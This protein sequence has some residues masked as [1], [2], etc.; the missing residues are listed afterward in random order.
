ML[1]AEYKYD[2]YE[3][4]DI[5]KMGIRT[6]YKKDYMPHEKKA[7]IQVSIAADGA[8]SIYR[9]YIVVDEIEDKEEDRQMLLK[10][11]KKI[12]KD[13]GLGDTLVLDI[14]PDPLEF[15]RI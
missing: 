10:D 6:A 15:T 9:E 12:K 8:I 5:V 2:P 1:I 7:Q 4:L 11:A 3:V 13:I 14:T